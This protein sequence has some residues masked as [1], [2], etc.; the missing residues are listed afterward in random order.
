[1]SSNTGLPMVLFTL[2]VLYT[3]YK[4]IFIYVLLYPNPR[5]HLIT[6]YDPPKIAFR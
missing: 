2:H 1:M 4:H 6:V 3:V 5:I